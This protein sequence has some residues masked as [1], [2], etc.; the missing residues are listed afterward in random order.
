[1]IT[2]SFQ[3]PEEMKLRLE[4]LASELDRSKAYLIREALTEYLEDLEDYLEARKVQA[5]TKPEEYIPFAEV[6]RQLGLN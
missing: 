5:A 1:M 6:K 4:A 2:L 3:A